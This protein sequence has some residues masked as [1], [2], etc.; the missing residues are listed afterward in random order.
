[1]SAS[2]E[3]LVPGI[4]LAILAS[5]HMNVGKGVQKWKV[6]ALAAGRGVLAA[7]TRR[8]FGIWLFGVALTTSASVLYS[9]ALK[10][11][12]TPSMVSALSG[13][14]I[15]GLVAFAAIVLREKVG[16]PEAIGALLVLAGTGLMGWFD[17][18]AGTP[19]AF[20]LRAFLGAAA[21]V[22][23]P[24]SLA[25]IVS[26]RARRFHGLAFGAL[27]GALLGVSIVLGDLALLAAGND[28][29][30]QLGH[31]YPYAALTVGGLA[32]TVTQF[33]FWR[34]TAISVVPTTN[35][36]VILV[37]VVLERFTLDRG[38][39]G[40]QYAAL[41]AIVAGVVLLTAVRRS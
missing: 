19:D 23:A 5:C 41:A 29:L 3:S 38:I 10:F 22:L 17:P 12:D 40:P 9:L 18:G 15:L 16:A 32:L 21:G 39:V 30:G 28:F 14:G 25:A 31:P 8:D 35:A 24:L 27:A 6:G 11:T 13:V 37:P 36:F 2:P 7:G 20:D 26:W 4:L 34:A 33:A 1:M